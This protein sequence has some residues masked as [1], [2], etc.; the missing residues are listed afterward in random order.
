MIALIGMQLCVDDRHVWL[1]RWSKTV[2]PREG[3]ESSNHGQYS[4]H[5]AVCDYWITRFRG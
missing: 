5:P 1:S 4:K 3:G 2:I